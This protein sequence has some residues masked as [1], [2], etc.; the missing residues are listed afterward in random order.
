MSFALTSVLVHDTIC[1]ELG[2]LLVSHFFVFVMPRIS[3]I[4]GQ[5]VETAHKKQEECKLNVSGEYENEII[6][7]TSTSSRTLSHTGHC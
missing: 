3:R 6:P 4:T 5:K 7:L 2:N 1:R